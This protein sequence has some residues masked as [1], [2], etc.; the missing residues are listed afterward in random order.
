MLIS[1]AAFSILHLLN[2]NPSLASSLGIFLAGLF[3]AYA[4][5]ASGQLWLPIGLHLGWN[6]FEGPIFGFSV[7]GLDLQTSVFFD[8]AEA[9][10][11]WATGG[12][13]GPEGGVVVTLVLV[14]GIFGL[15]YQS[16]KKA[17]SF[18]GITDNMSSR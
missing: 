13:F 14:G 5:L 16:R 17:R 2:P 10:P 8:L 3:L 7:S 9:G 4:C 15:V 11:D 12:L 18:S 1:S 6:F